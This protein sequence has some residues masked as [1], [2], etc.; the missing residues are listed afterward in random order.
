MIADTVTWISSGV[1][2]FVNE[3]MALIGPIVF[4]LG[5][6]E[7]IAFVS[8]LV[9]S[10][11]LFLGIGGLH[12]A[13]GGSFWEVWLYG[14]AGA[15]IG[16]VLSYLVGRYFKDEMSGVWPFN[17]RPEWYLLAR[18]Y[19]DEYGSVGI[20]GSKFLGA[21]RPFVP[22][23]AGAMRMPFPV[24]IAASAASCLAWAGAF[25]SPGYGIGYLLR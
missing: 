2:T 18:R 12:H 20:I 19:S 10:T 22:M 11:L 5:F 21:L 16:D 25:L 14:A 13:A 1:M 9:P 3:N 4:A 24:F 6:A 17:R 7:S 8:L 23:V 15:F